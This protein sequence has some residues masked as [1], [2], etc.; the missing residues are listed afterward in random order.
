[1]SQE[2]RLNGLRGQQLG[3][4][5]VFHQSVIKFRGRVVVPAAPAFVK[6]HP[7]RTS[8]KKSAFCRR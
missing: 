4:I 7:M 5:L 8:I 2:H 1:M 6:N 3:T